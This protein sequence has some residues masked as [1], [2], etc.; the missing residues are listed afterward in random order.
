M[1]QFLK[2]RIFLYNI[3]GAIAVFIIVFWL[4]TSAL[5]SYTR[6]GETITVPD[7]SGMT[8]EKAKQILSDRNLEIAIADSAFNDKKPKMAVLEQNPSANSKVKEGRTIYLTVNAKIPPQVKMP[9]LTDNSL[10]QAQMILEN[11]GLRVGQLIYKPDLAQNV[12]LDWMVRGRHIVIG[13]NIKKGSTVDL[14]L[15][16]GLGNTEVEVPELIGHTLR[17]VKFILDASSLNLGAVIADNTVRGDSLNAI[18]YKQTPSP[19]DTDNKLNLGEAVDVYITLD[20]F[21][22]DTQEEE[23]IK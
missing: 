5:N 23:E 10:K 7:L 22:L 12:V 2:S 18:V 20:Q 19:I 3:L 6:H 21:K 17:E 9:D 1:W 13:D 15:G 11:I 16:D 14:I 8:F 4:G